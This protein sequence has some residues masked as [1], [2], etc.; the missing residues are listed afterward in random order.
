MERNYTYVVTCINCQQFKIPE[1]IE[2]FENIH[3]IFNENFNYV[4]ENY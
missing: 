1:R 2:F 3:G 4:N